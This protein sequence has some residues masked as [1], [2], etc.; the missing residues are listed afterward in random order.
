M[1][2]VALAAVAVKLV[3]LLAETAVAEPSYELLGYVEL[4]KLDE[5]CW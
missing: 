5:V 2:V 1:V 4:L 3:E